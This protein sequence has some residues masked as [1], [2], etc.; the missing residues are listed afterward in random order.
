M[1]PAGSRHGLVAMRF[2]ARLDAHV[3]AR[4]LGVVFAA[5]TGFVLRRDPDTVRAPDTA[6][7]ALDRAPLAAS[8]EGYFPGAPDLAVEVVS[9]SDSFQEVQEKVLEWLA[10]GTRAVVVVDPKRRLTSLYRSREDIRVLTDSETLD[11]DVAVPGF[12]LPLLDLF[13]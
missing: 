13:E 3:R 2:A 4:S 1:T 11:L 5:E 8:T 10:A 7:V 6:F 12:R 9:P